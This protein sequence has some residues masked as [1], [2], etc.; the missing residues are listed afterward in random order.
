MVDN[1]DSPRAGEEAVPGPGLV[2][3]DDRYRKDRDLVL[4]RQSERASLERLQ[5]A[6][7]GAISLGENH[8]CLP[9]FEEAYC[10][11]GS[12][13]VG[14]LD[15]DREGAQVSDQPS[16][17]R[18]FE[19]PVPGHEVDRPPEGKDHERRIGVRDVIGSNDEGSLE[20]DVLDAFEANAEVDARD[21]PDRWMERLGGRRAHGPI[22]T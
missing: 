20:R 22:V 13:R 10:F 12:H 17:E 19:E 8:E 2:P 14:A 18:D 21:R 15:L 1:G 4:T 7:V 5:A 9:G 11:P 6:I 3:A 16:K